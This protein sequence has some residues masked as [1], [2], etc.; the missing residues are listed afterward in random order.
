MPDRALEH[1]PNTLCI[2]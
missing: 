1:A 2:R